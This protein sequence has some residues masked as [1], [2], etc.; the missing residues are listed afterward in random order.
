VRPPTK[1]PPVPLGLG[2]KELLI[3]VVPHT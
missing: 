1:V 2:V 3:G